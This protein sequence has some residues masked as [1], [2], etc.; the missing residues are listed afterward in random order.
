MNKP[1]TTTSLFFGL[2]L[3]AMTTFAAP[4]S[5]QGTGQ[6][7]AAEIDL[8]YYPEGVT[9]SDP[10]ARN[11]DEI[12]R[13]AAELAML[14]ADLPTLDYERARHHPIHFPPMIKTASNEQCLTCHQEVLDHQPRA[15]SPAGVPAGDT[16]AWYQTLDTYAG[17]QASFHWRHL[18]SDYARAVMNLECTFCHK[19]NDPREES[20]DMMPLRA[21][22][23]A[24]ATPE[25]TLRK[26]VNPSTTCLMC[27]GAMP[28]VDEIM[29]IG[30][31]WPG[32][33][34]DF[35]DE[36]TLNG[37]LSCHYG[38][39]TDRHNVSFLN[40]ATI[41]HLGQTNGSDSCYGC[42]GGRQWYRI[43]Y[44]YPRHAWP[45]MDEDTPEWAAGRPTQSD[46]AYQRPPLASE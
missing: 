13:I 12:A 38:I 27:H 5:G 1:E 22:F 17:D 43:S 8:D 9:Y 31:P 16:I 42:H 10:P 25:F 40:A 24:D 37:C 33:R 2:A 6:D 23:S 11:D 20:P 4:V 30:A 39:R 21:T 15:V 18:E 19:G 46:P 44:P 3:V 41:E 36:D 35:E 29:G 45:D 32:A 14:K 26:M 34:L 28:D 7:A